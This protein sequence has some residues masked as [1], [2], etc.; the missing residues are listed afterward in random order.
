MR[1]VLFVA[2]IMAAC[3]A[4]GLA[5][6][7]RAG[8]LRISHPGCTFVEARPGVLAAVVK[9]SNGGN[10]DDRLIGASFATAGDVRLDNHRIEDMPGIVIPAGAA[11]VLKPSVIPLT[12][13]DIKSMPVEGQTVSGTLTFARAG[14]IAVDFEIGG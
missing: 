6:D 2:V 7:I 8:D 11:L 5:H 13:A 12:F 9:I 14:T 10:T 3:P 1:K 4:V